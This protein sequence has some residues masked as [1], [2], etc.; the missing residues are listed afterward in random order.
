MAKNDSRHIPHRFACCA[1]CH[2][3]GTAM[4]F[5]LVYGGFYRGGDIN[6]CSLLDMGVA[7]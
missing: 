6:R 2:R 1:L 5:A 7:A 4:A 3:V